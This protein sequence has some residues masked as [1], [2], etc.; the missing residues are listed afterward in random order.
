M[1]Y[2]IYGRTPST[3][4]FLCDRSGYA[5]ACTREVVFMAWIAVHEQIDSAKLRQLRK[6]IGCSKLEALGILV[7][8]WLWGL[9]NTDRSGV[10]KSA[11]TDDV[12]EIFA[13]GLSKGIA[14]AKVVRALIDTG[15]IDLCGDQMIIHDWEDWQDQWY[16]ALDR[17]EKDKARKHGNSMENPWNFQCNRH[18]HRYLHRQKRRQRTAKL[19]PRL[20][21]L[22]ARLIVFGECTRRKLGNR[23]L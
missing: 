11:D 3:V 22:T 4:T 17:R 20:S 21:A 19:K 5:E 14:P 10:L 6:E 2:I 18:R 1:D 12:A 15:W 8:L 16:K 7:H 9:D 13:F 23:P